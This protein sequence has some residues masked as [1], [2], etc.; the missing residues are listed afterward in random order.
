[1]RIAS[2]RHLSG[3]PLHTSRVGTRRA[4]A[5]RRAAL[6]CQVVRLPSLQR[7]DWPHPNGGSSSILR[8]GGDGGW[9]HSVGST[10][11]F[12]DPSPSGFPLSAAM[13][14]PSLTL[15]HVKHRIDGASAV[16]FDNDGTLV[17][18]MPVQMI[19]WQKALAHHRL[20]FPEHKFYA[21]AGMPA[22]G[23]IPPLAEEQNVPHAVKPVS[24]VVE[25]LHYARQKCLP[26]AVASG[27]EREDVLTSL[28]YSD[29]NVSHFGAVVTAEDRVRV[30][31][32]DCIGFEDADKGMQALHN[33]GMEAVD[34]RTIHGYPLPQ[35]LRAPGE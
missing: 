28:R 7:V 17:D 22:S 12:E 21:M 24:I 9:K 30:N 27:G 33:A 10:F 26:I 34:V 2:V 1:M 16:I 23:I 15:E 14:T 11:P 19:A 8:H 32:S 20:L 6:G 25:L 18:S 29:I 31:P 5:R 4:Q 35:C 3:A 13:I